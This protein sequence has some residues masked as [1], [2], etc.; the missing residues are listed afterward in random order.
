MLGTVARLGILWHSVHPC[1]V[2]IGS[3]WNVISGTIPSS[4]LLIMTHLP[5]VYQAC[6]Y[7]EPGQNKVQVREDMPLPEPGP[8][9]ILINL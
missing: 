1:P 8:G 2:F 7:A 3:D 9:E 5:A 6:C 4:K